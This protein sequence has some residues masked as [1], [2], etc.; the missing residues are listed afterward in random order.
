MSYLFPLPLPYVMS[1]HKAQLRVFFKK[2]KKKRQKTEVG[3]KGMKHR[4][5]SDLWSRAI[6]KGMQR[7][8][9]LLQHLYFS[10]RSE[11]ALLVAIW[12]SYYSFGMH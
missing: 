4:Q 10:S 6:P 11:E 8:V 1:P 7:N 5:Q 9:W 2:K 3:A 12:L